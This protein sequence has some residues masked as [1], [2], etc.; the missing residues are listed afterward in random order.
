MAKKH[1]ASGRHLSVVMP[2]TESVAV[3]A[4]VRGMCAC[5]THLQAVKCSEKK[6]WSCLRC[7]ALT[8]V[9]KCTAVQ[10]RFSENARRTEVV[11][12]RKCGRG[13]AHSVQGA[14]SHRAQARCK[15]ERAARA[16]LGMTVPRVLLLGRS[17]RGGPV[18]RYMYLVSDSDT[19]TVLEYCNSY[20]TVL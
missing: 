9:L 6:P 12:E 2:I 18:N 7:A 17:A 20:I 14:Q 1:G 10:L 4:R 19:I 5:V 8:D 3:R 15:I 16:R 11:N 13:S